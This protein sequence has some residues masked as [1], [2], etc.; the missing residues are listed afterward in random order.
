MHMFPLGNMCKGHTF[1]SG[2]LCTAAPF[3]KDWLHLHPLQ[4]NLI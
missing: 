3:P 1:P 2:M 4:I